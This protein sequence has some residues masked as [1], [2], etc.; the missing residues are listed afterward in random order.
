MRVTVTPAFGKYL[1][2]N[3]TVYPY[4]MLRPTRNS[5]YCKLMGHVVQGLDRG[6]TEYFPVLA[7]SLPNV[8]E[9]ILSGRA[10]P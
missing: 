4:S 6:S 9:P 7:N 2:D 5:F 10:K 3:S 8:P 1:M